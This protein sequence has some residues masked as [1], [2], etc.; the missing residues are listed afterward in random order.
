MTIDIV[1][2]LFDCQ[3]ENSGRKIANI[4][5]YPKIS[6]DVKI[7]QG[8]SLQVVEAVG[9]GAYGVVC[10]AKARHASSKTGMG[11]WVKYGQVWSSMVK[12]G[13]VI[14]VI[15]TGLCTCYQNLSSNMFQGFGMKDGFVPNMAQT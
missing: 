8:S 9:Q 11:Q 5:R 6:Q 2:Q 14:S 15:V 4:P 10:S 7:C 3:S 1:D 13:Q 12:Y